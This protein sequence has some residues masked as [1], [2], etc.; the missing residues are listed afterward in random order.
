MMKSGCDET[1]RPAR[2]PTPGLG[3]VPMEFHCHF[4]LDYLIKLP[5]VDLTGYLRGGT[6]VEIRAALVIM[7]AQ[8]R[9]YFVGGDCTNILADGSCGGHVITELRGHGE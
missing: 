8:G 4:D 6:A 1:G 9:H 5:D 7:K 2:R 3:F